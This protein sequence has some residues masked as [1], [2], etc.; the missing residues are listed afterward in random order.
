MVRALWAATKHV[1][2]LAASRPDLL[3]SSIALVGARRLECQALGARARS[4]HAVGTCTCRAGCGRAQVARKE[5]R[6]PESRSTAGPMNAAWGAR[7]ARCLELGEACD[8][9]IAVQDV[10]P[11]GNEPARAGRQPPA[12]GRS[13]ADRAAP[14]VGSP[15]TGLPGLGRALRVCEPSKAAAVM[16]RWGSARRPGCAYGAEMAEKCA[17][18]GGLAQCGPPPSPRRRRR[19]RHPAPP[20]AAPPSPCRRSRQLQSQWLS[21]ALRNYSDYD[22]NART[23]ACLRGLAA[24]CAVALRVPRVGHAHVALPPAAT[25][26]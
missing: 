17:I 13:G 15:E 11:G 10:P 23:C 7:N 2:R 4:R 1:L 16:R 6:G 18:A 8:H 26:A 5:A 19:C 9:P 25:R 14:R 3:V 20:A 24:C 21:V 22:I 12:G